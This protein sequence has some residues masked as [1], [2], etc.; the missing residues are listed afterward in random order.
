MTLEELHKA[1]DGV[2]AIT[3]SVE[4]LGVKQNHL[5]ALESMKVVCLADIAY[6]LERIADCS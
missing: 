1:I 5:Y 3:E 4:G 2:N 6:S